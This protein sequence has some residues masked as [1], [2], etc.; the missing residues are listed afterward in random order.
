[1][2]PVR[3]VPAGDPRTLV[4][5]E[6]PYTIDGELAVDDEGKTIKGKTPVTFE[7]PRFDFIDE[8]QFDEITEELKALDEKDLSQRKLSR[9]VALVMLRHFVDDNIY[10]LLQKLRTGELDQMMEAWRNASSV[11]L[12]E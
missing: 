6:L 11:S 1:M 5:F 4:P 12:G 3:V 8:D 7:V 10:T 2:K 9:E